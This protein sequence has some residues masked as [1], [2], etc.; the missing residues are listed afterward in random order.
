M[1]TDRSTA[2]VAPESLLRSITDR[3]PARVTYYDRDLVCRFANIAHAASYGCQ[4]DEL[5]GRHMSDIV[6]PAVMAEIL[7]RIADALSGQPQ[8][9]EAV[10]RDVDGAEHCYEIHYV[11]DSRG[12]EVAGI[13]IELHDISERKR[14]EEL[15]LNANQELEERVRERTAELYASEQRYRL[16]SEAIAAAG[17]CAIGIIS[18]KNTP[19]AT[20]RATERRLT[21]HSSGSWI[22]GPSQRSRRLCV[23]ASRVGRKRSS[24]VRSGAKTASYA[25]SAKAQEAAPR[26]VR[27]GR[28]A[29][30]SG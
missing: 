24:M 18:P 13:F 7:P 23:M 19:I 11:P 26:G 28:V 3:I 25:M 27:G 17:I 20:P 1:D 2:A 16:M 21:C 10:R 14:T 15:V 29:A 5:L 22:R 8:R 4:P 6:D 12:D 30:A 9:F